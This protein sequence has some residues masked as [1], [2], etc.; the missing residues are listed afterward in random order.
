MHSSDVLSGR[1]GA[2]V[3]ERIY[4]LVPREFL[5]HLANSKVVE[6]RLAGKKMSS[7]G[8]FVPETFSALKSFVNQL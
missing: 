5:E 4:V 1:N 6:F 3:T 8:K 7:Q 2:C